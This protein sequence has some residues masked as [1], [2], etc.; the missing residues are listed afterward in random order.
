VDL[1][2]GPSPDEIDYT[3]PLA[4]DASG[5]VEVQV[6][7]TP[8]PY[9]AV[10]G[11]GMDSRFAT[12]N[13][14]L[15]GVSNFRDMGG[16]RSSLPGSVGSKDR[17]PR[18]VKWGRLYRSSDFNELSDADRRVVRGLGL[19]QVI[20]FRALDEQEKRPNRFAEVHEINETSIP[21]DPGSGV[22]FRSMMLDEKF[23]P[24]F[25]TDAMETMNRILIRD[26]CDDYRQMFDV[27]LAGDG[28]P[29]AIN[30][31]SGKDRTG[32]GAALILMSLGVDRESILHDYL[33]T[34]VYLRVQDRVTEGL[35]NMARYT[36]RKIDPEIVLPMYDARRIYLTA[37]LDEID[38][39]FGG[40]EAYFRD[41]LLFDD[42]TFSRMRE[43]YLEELT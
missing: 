6:D 4:S 36:D 8:R 38:V 10:R 43:L 19:K 24:S 26:H 9:F 14:P 5:S 35:E 17:A 21:I 29:T 39:L 28:S 11:K 30:C 27:I 31:A 20:D 23:S 18:H 33:L 37:A 25:M 15:S 41:G 16:Y 34:N 3:T 32:V 2:A 42:A 13:V 1:F 22:G 7:S 40:P 12:R